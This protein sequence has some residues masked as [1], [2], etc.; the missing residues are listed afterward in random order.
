[1]INK[2]ARIGTLYLSTEH[3]TD[4]ANQTIGKPSIGPNMGELIQNRRNVT[5]HVNFEGSV[6]KLKVAEYFLN[7]YGIQVKFQW[8]ISAGCTM[9]PCSPGFKIIA[10]VSMQYN[11][12]IREKE[13]FDVW[14][15]KDNTLDVRAPK[16]GPYTY[17]LKKLE[18]VSA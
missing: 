9:C 16:Y 5:N 14:V 2:K 3:F 8:S 11:S 17:E 1:M 4:D 15:R 10:E 18:E 12:R 7:T 13:R 6:A